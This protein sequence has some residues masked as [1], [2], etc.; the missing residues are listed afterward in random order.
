MGNLTVNQVNAW[1]N[2]RKPMLKGDGGQLYF[3]VSKGGSSSWIFRYEKAGRQIW[4]GLG[5]LGDVS[6]ASA[7][8]SAESHRA[9]LRAGLCPKTER[10]RSKANY[11]EALSAS[12]SFESVA[13]EYMQG[14]LD[15]WTPKHAKE[16][17]NSLANHVYPK[18]AQRK[19]CLLYTSPSPRDATLSRMPS[20]A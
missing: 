17:R 6:L 10:E 7:R 8:L 14:R 12:R 5:P 13:E 3:Q 11:A 4:L 2:E 1:A 19:I 16:W 18:L 15:S 20:S 9:E